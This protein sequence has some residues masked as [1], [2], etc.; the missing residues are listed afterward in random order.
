MN[1]KLVKVIYKIKNSINNKL[2]IGATNNVRLRWNRH[3]YN[4]RSGSNLPLYCDMRKYGIEQFSIEEIETTGNWENREK[5]WI[6][7]LK[8]QNKKFG[9][10]IMPGGIYGVGTTWRNPEES[11]K[12]VIAKTKGK[13]RNKEFGEKLREMFK[14]RKVSQ[15]QKEKISKTLKKKYK[16]GELTGKATSGSF[17]CKKLHP[18]YKDVNKHEMK[19]LIDSGMVISEAS[20]ILGIA[21][22]TFIKK[23][24]EYFGIG[25]REYKRKGI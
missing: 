22:R 6:K 12:K 19:E 21:E 11:I 15:E 3:K 10:N 2:Y 5:Y 13:K 18:K 14:G 7:E 1:L 4:C 17:M 9:Y 25:V 20:K 8:T 24:K 16:N 23:F